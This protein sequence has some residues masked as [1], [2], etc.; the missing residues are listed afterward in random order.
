MEISAVP[1]RERW[2][3]SPRWHLC[4]DQVAA[5]VDDLSDSA[6]YLDTKEFS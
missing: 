2:H 1:R 4:A 3:A 5:L 6:R